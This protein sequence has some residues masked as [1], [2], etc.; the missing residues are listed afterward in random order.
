MTEPELTKAA[1]LQQNEELRAR[2]AQAEGAREELERIQR[3]HEES[4]R[5]LAHELR[6]PLNAILGWSQ[7]LEKDPS[8]ASEGLAV[9]A[10]SARMQAQLLSDLVDRASARR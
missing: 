5:T 7:I 1:L 3:I 4:L 8:R 6:A 9:I 10:R 2:L